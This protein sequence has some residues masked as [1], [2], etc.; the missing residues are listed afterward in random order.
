LALAVYR[1]HAVGLS[2]RMASRF[3]KKRKP[4]GCFGSS[5][6]EDY[7]VRVIGADEIEHS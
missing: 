2:L 4:V 3:D 6:C 7:G 5:E 1:R